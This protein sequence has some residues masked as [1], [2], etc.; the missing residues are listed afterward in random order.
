MHVFTADLAAKRSIFSTIGLL[1]RFV[2]DW[3]A[4][5]QRAPCRGANTC[6]C[7]ALFRIRY[8]GRLGKSDTYLSVSKVCAIC[9]SCV[10]DE[11]AVRLDIGRL[12]ISYQINL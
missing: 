5:A 2:G 6:R 11:R 10:Y 4:G 9:A 1:G 3:L 8:R 12:Q 7:L